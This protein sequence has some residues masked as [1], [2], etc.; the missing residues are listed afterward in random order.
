VILQVSGSTIYSGTT[1]L[2]DMFAP[3]DVIS[4]GTF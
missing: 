4:G 2:L 1:S 3:Y